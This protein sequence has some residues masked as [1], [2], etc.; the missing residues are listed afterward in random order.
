MDPLSFRQVDISLL[1]EFITGAT[2]IFSQNNTGHQ[3]GGR[4]CRQDDAV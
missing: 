4:F 1:S 3:Y 2:I